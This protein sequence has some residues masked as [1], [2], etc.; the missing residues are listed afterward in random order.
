[1]KAPFKFKTPTSLLSRVREI[2][3]RSHVLERI[4]SHHLVSDQS[5]ERR[6]CDQNRN[7]TLHSQYD[8]RRDVSLLLFVAARLSSQHHRRIR[9][10][11]QGRQ[12]HRSFILSASMSKVEINEI[13]M[14]NNLIS[15]RQ[16]LQYVR[17][18]LESVIYHPHRNNFTPD[19]RNTHYDVR[20]DVSSL[21]HLP[22][23]LPFQ[24]HRRIPHLDLFCQRY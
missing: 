2:W 10:P 5:Y 9:L 15:R 19:T 13:A 17:N 24:Q 8:G 20:R 23:S 12:R 22:P 18:N 1:M 6:T 14:T 21:L 3:R 16:L 7:D 4:E 11:K